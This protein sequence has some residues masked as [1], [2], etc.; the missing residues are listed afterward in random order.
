M[1]KNLT[2]VRYLYQGLIFFIDTVR[3]L[4]SPVHLRP[5]LARSASKKRRQHH[6]D[7]G[8]P[9]NDDVDESTAKKVCLKAHCLM[10]CALLIFLSL[11]LLLWKIAYSETNISTEAVHSYIRPSA[12]TG[13]KCLCR[14]QLPLR[15]PVARAQPN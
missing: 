4:D 15:D 12:L 10:H 7:V 13:L 3:D 14:T 5:A 8:P 9:K 2:I 11:P 1:S 6:E